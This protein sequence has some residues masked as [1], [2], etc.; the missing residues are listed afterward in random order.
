M[1]GPG[2]VDDELQDEVKG[3]CS[4]TYGPVIKCVIYE[5]TGRV[6]PEEAVRIFVQFRNPGDATRGT[7]LARALSS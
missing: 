2:Q 3:E 6:P 5:V 4:E 1:V 7:V